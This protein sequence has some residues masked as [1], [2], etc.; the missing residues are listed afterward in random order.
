MCFSPKS[1]RRHPAQNGPQQKVPE[2][3]SA[4]VD[5]PFSPSVLSLESTPCSCFSPPLGDADAFPDASIFLLIF[6]EPRL[7]IRGSG[8]ALPSQR[9]Q[10]CASCS[11]ERER[12]EL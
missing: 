9:P 3:S 6:F 4:S 7:V 2:V 10:I 5:M 1:S 11:S 8:E 12:R